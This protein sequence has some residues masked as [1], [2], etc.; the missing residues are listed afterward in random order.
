M[1][2]V[3]ALYRRILERGDCLSLRQ[4]A[5][6]G[7]DLMEAGIPKGKQVGAIL[8]KLFDEVLQDPDLNTKEYLIPR[9]KL[10]NLG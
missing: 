1:D 8:G 4:L 5:V 2:Q 10:L 7:N 3:E 9:A 6:T